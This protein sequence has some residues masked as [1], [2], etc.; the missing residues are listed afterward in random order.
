MSLAW[1][2]PPI[3]TDGG[4]ALGVPSHNVRTVEVLV[5]HDA[6]TFGAAANGDPW[7]YYDLVHLHL[8]RTVPAPDRLRTLRLLHPEELQPRPTPGGQGESAENAGRHP[9]HRR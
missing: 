2:Q 8:R 3:T 4:M 7:Q 9:S 6:V 5:D 1:Q